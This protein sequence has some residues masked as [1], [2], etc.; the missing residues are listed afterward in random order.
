MGIIQYN[1]FSTNFVIDVARSTLFP[2]Q[3]TRYFIY[4]FSPA[5]YLSVETPYRWLNQPYV[6]TWIS[7]IDSSGKKTRIYDEEVKGGSNLAA[8][9]YTNNVAVSTGFITRYIDTEHS[10]WEIG[11]KCGNNINYVNSNFY[12]ASIGKIK[13]ESLYTSYFKGEYIKGNP[14]TNSS[15]VSISSS[16]EGIRSSKSVLRSIAEFSGSE[17][18]NMFNPSSAS[19]FMTQAAD[20][21]LNAGIR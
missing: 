10:L 11:L 9:T 1:N 16:F 19:G 7:Y 15:V 17:V 12:I 20:W 21:R 3:G 5:W 8:V 14:K 4:F 2:N 13:S 18:I 6:Y